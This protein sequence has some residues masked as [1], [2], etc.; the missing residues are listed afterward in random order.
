MIVGSVLE[1]LG[2]LYSMGTEIF[3]CEPLTAEIIGFKFQNI[4]KAEPIFSIVNF[5]NHFKWLVEGSYICTRIR[6]PWSS[7]HD[8]MQY[9]MLTGHSEKGKLW[10]L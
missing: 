9:S 8:S 10:W 3:P 2:I 1:N 7:E 5:L 4:P 6:Y